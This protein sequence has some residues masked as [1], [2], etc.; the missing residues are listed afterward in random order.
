MPAEVIPDEPLECSQCNSTDEQASLTMDH[1]GNLLCGDC[2]FWCD[3]CEEYSSDF[4][5]SF[6]MCDSC[7]E[8]HA[9]CEECG[10]VVSQEDSHYHEWRWHC[11][12]CWESR[13]YRRFIH[14]YGYK[15]EPIFHL[16]GQQVQVAPPDFWFLGLEIE[17]ENPS[18]NWDQLENTVGDESLWYAKEDGSLTNGVEF[19]SHP[20]EHSYLLE[21]F[22][23]LTEPITRLRFH[24]YSSFNTQTCGIHLHVSRSAFRSELHLLKFVSLFVPVD[25][26]PQRTISGIQLGGGLSGSAED[27]KALL[28]V[29]R[30][31]LN[32]ITEYCS[33]DIGLTKVSAIKASGSGKRMASVNLQNPNTVEL[34]IFRG[35]LLP[36][37]LKSYIQITVAGVEYARE[38]AI[39][40]ARATRLF[41]FIQ[42]E[43]TKQYPEAVAML[44]RRLDFQSSDERER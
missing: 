37:S 10:T 27:I 29:S 34:R 4:S 6:D 25:H 43:R 12:T 2:R 14:N 18:Q 36:D 21:S 42:N 40:L 32:Q 17:T 35:T 3:Q 16:P 9:R 30:R 20:I 7:A 31:G 28:A 22:S 11:G 23:D 19:V 38:C 1:S 13:E 15:P 26:V 24:G 41:R 44:E 5:D 39:P 8:D 33:L